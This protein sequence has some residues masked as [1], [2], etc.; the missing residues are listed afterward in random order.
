MRKIF[1]AVIAIMVTSSTPSAWGAQTSFLCRPVGEEGYVDVV[2]AGKNNR[3]LVQ[4]NGG[5]FLEGQ[6]EFENPILYV[7]VPVD[8]GVIVLA[9][10]VTKGIAAMVAKSEKKET[11]IE[12]VCKF[13]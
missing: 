10:D 8:V 1:W 6:A 13:R 4:F 7:T 5:N 9:F 12:M 3:V 2:S 11:V